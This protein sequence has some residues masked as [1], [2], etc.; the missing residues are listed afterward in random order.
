[1]KLTRLLSLVIPYIICCSAYAQYP[2]RITH[3]DEDDGLIETEVFQGLQ[4]AEGLIWF[5]SRNGLFRY[6]SHRF[7][8]FKAYPGDD[9][10]L[11]SN[12]IERFVESGDS[13]ICLSQEKAYFFDKTTGRFSPA[14]SLPARKAQ[15]PEYDRL[16]EQ[17]K[18]LP[19]FRGIDKV[20]V[21][22]VDRQGGI[23][24][25]TN[26]GLHRIERVAKKATPVKTGGEAEEEVRALMIDRDGNKWV[27]DKNRFLKIYDRKGRLAYLT[28]DGSVTSSRQPF[29]F[30]AY[31]IYEDKRGRIWIGCKPGGLFRLERKGEKYAIR[32]FPAGK[33]KYALNCDA[34]YDITEDRQGRLWIATYGGGVNMLDE[35]ADGSVQFVNKGNALAAYPADAMFIH[36]I[37]ITR[38][39]I[40]AAATTRGLVTA[41]VAEKVSE[42]RFHTNRR[43]ANDVSSLP[44]D[45]LTDVTETGNDRLVITTNG[46]GICCTGTKG[47]DLLKD[48]IRFLTFNSQGNI[49]TDVFMSLTEDHQGNLWAVG[50]TS[51]TKIHKN[52]NRIEIFKKSHFDGQFAFSEAMPVC[53]K[54]GMMTFGTTQGHLTINLKEM[55]KNSFVPYI[56][57][58]SPD[59]IRLSPEEKSV[60]VNFSAIDFNRHEPI[61]YAYILEG[62]DRQWQYTLD[63]HIYYSNLPGGTYRL[64]VKSTNSDGVWTDNE[65]CI[66]IIRR[67]AFNE[68]RT[69]WM[70][71][72]IL[73]IVSVLAIYYTTRYIRRLR[74]EMTAYQLKA[75]EQ[76]EY[77]ASR[78]RELAAHNSEIVSD[79]KTGGEEEEEDFA[80]KAKA[81]MREH[82]GDN[83]I[84]V[85]SF[86][87]Y[88]NMSKS[89]FYLKCKK[90]LGYTPSNYIQ[91]TRLSY[92]SLL[93]KNSATSNISDIA[94]KCGFSDPKYFS[95]LFKKVKGVT[96]TEYAAQNQAAGH[97]G[98]QQK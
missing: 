95:R 93:L 70:L 98:H 94:Y 85:E 4:D 73:L 9:C 27:A 22:L 30:R 97:A 8:V 29:G 34:I 75:S 60:M 59:T 58:Y 65:K 87:R 96:P 21:R 23:W 69:A 52:G 56:K 49:A 19:E 44:T 2:Y 37:A 14:S 67:P 82:I 50:K 55:V 15:D 33:E 76:I 64:R 62:L 18:N 54:D 81:Y 35:K 86:A 77:M 89:L 68:T 53:D 48:D 13:F 24:V 10:P 78:I 26:R 6:D 61:R 38:N 16:R 3:Y 43:R 84:S 31:C 83:E 17:I 45:Y 1:M 79:G 39:G 47:S 80:T 11:Q 72:G 90:H 36:G 74:K 28:P 91:N 25:R 63:N 51:L 66:T 41:R 40:L 5:A 42:T 7:M 57:I 12:R 71:Y 20:K 92:A 88:M 46:G 32:H